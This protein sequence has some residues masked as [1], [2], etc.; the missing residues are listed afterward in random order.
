MP[1]HAERQ[2]VP[3]SPDQLFDLANDPQEEV[4]LATDPNAAE[5]LA[6]FQA[7]ATARGERPVYDS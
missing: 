1:T 2:I 7:A 3:Y 5:I 4:N 6:H